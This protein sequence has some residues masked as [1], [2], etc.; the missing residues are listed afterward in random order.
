M[1]K[2]DKVVSMGFHSESAL[3]ISPRQALEQAIQDI[4]EGYF[5]GKKVLIITLDDTGAD[6]YD[7]G[8]LQAGMSMAECLG[9]CEVIKTQFLKYMAYL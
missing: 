4:D 3:R 9:L 2:D 8:F 1:G 6:V 5:E 7:A